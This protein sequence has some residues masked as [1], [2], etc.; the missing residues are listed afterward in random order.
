MQ[1]YLQRLVPY[2]E[3]TPIPKQTLIKRIRERMS[4]EDG[5]IRAIVNI[6]YM[7]RFSEMWK[8]NDRVEML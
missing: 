3:S 4:G 2:L 1:E 6:L 5:T 7:L 8:R